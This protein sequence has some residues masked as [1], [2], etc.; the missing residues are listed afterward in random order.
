MAE[1]L[2][3]DTPAPARVWL[4]K[5][6]ERIGRDECV[7]AVAAARG[8]QGP[9]GARRRHPGPGEQPRSVRR[10]EAPRGR[11]RAPRSASLKVALV[12]ALGFRAEPE[13]C[14]PCWPRNCSQTMPTLPR[15]PPGHWARSATPE[16]I[17]ALEGSAETAGAVRSG[18]RSATP[19]RKCGASA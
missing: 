7:A 10:R 4:L 12:N 19:W 3:P 14:E 5:Q 17:E 18:S 1:K 2:G 6:L 9:A 8:R 13:S 11:C 16:A 15:P